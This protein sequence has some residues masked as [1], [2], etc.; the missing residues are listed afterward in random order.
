MGTRRFS[1][2]VMIA[3]AYWRKCGKRLKMMPVYM[4]KEKKSIEFGNLIQ[5][6]PENA[7]ADEQNRIIRETEEQIFAMAGI[8]P[9]PEEEKP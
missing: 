7:F 2:F 1:G 8:V 9:E 3:A 6:D 4:N 5:F